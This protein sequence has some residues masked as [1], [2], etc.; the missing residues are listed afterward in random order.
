MLVSLLIMLITNTSNRLCLRTL[1][2]S[3]QLIILMKPSK[4]FL[5]LMFGQNNNNKDIKLYSLISSATMLLISGTKVS[6]ISMR[7]Y[8]MTVSG[9]I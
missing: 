5:S 3:L 7:K 2:S 8:H 1:L 9:S 4:E 6:K